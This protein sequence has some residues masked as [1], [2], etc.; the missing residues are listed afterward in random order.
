MFSV[1]YELLERWLEQQI[2]GELETDCKLRWGKFEE[3]GPA[4]S[5]KKR[6]TKC[7]GLPSDNQ[8][9]QGKV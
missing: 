9:C 5:V 7:S 6:D 3:D 8:P 2:D 1:Q 4:M